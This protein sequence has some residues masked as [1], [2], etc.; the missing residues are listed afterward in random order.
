MGVLYYFLNR[1]RWT[2]VS[3]IKGA[4]MSRMPGAKPCLKRV[5]ERLSTDISANRHPERT[6]ME[7]R[8]RLDQDNVT[9]R[10]LF[11][12]LDGLSR[13]LKS[14]YGPGPNELT[15]PSDPSIRRIP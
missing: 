9:G 11:P 12:E 6:E 13:W 10:M 2:P 8:D 15:P 14:Y 5:S 4:I 3:S 7:L 1:R